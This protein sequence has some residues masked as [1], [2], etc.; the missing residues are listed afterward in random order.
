MFKILKLDLAKSV[1]SMVVEI[2]TILEIKTMKKNLKDFKSTLQHLADSIHL[3]FSGYISRRRFLN[4]TGV[5]KDVH[6]R[7]PCCKF[8]LLSVIFV[9][10]GHC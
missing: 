3:L 2:M 7:S 6:P 8:A 1:E 4:N 5:A 10:N 9:H